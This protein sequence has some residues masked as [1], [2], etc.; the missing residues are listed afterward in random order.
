MLGWSISKVDQTPIAGPGGHPGHRR[1]AGTPQRVDPTPIAEPEETE[2][3][4]AGVKGLA[5]PHCL[6]EY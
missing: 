6:I 1:W 3:T 4:D 5:F 2:V